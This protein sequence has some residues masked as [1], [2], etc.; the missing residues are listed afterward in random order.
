[1]L[2]LNLLCAAEGQDDSE[3]RGKPTFG[4]DAILTETEMEFQYL[5]RRTEENVKKSGV[6]HGGADP[7][8]LE[9][10]LSLIHLV[11]FFSENWHVQDQKLCHRLV[12]IIRNQQDYLPLLRDFIFKHFHGE[13]IYIYTFIYCCVSDGHHRIT[14]YMYLQN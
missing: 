8:T 7:E 12:N 5:L 6:F 9:L 13:C 2:L 11:S 4:S 14:L 3:I 1:M 10:T